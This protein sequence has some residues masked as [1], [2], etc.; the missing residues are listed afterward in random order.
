M[1]YSTGT[2][3]LLAA[4]LDLG[5][6]EDPKQGSSNSIYELLVSSTALRG[7]LSQ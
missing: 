2:Y 4:L 7:D 6:T 1:Y 3:S 5:E